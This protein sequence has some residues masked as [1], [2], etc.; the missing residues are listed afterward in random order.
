VADDIDFQGDIFAVLEA[1]RND[2]VLR[3][4]QWS[5]LLSL[6]WSAFR[7]GAL[8][9]PPPPPSEE[10]HVRG[11][12][13]SRNRDQAAITHHYDIGNEFYR[14]VLGPTLTYSCARFAEPHATLEE[15][16]CA[17]HDLICKKLG[18]DQLR[19]PRLLDVGSGWGSMAIHAAERYNARVV[20]V[21]LSPDQANEARA[22]VRR[23]GLEDRVEVRLGDYRDLR[24]ETFDAACSIGMFEH[25]GKRHMDDYFAILYELL[26]T[27]GR[28]LNHAISKVGGSV[29]KGRKFMHRYVFPDGELIDVAEVAAAM[30]RAGLEIRDV[31]S[32]REHYSRTLHAWVGNLDAGWERASSLVGESRAR[33]WRLYMAASANAF[34]ASS[35]AVHQ[36]LGVKADGSGGS[37]MP[38]TRR[39]WE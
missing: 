8:R 1:L 12:R 26:A 2:T 9:P 38:L 23:A 17:K 20:A 27:R 33:V 30:E 16:Q 7:M 28:M 11:P 25:V 31:E 19:E 13:H 10:S 36:V 22:R 29:M 34:D 4:M 14:I 32:L 39:S 21:T 15:A 35:I 37:G 24:G 3:G 6:W 18:L 5:M